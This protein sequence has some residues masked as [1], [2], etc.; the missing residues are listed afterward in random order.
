MLYKGKIPNSIVEENL[1]LIKMIFL[2]KRKRK[3]ACVI[4]TDNKRKRENPQ[5]SRW[6]IDF[7]KFHS[8]NSLTFWCPRL[9]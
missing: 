6:V 3:R 9:G 1:E 8:A 4:K 5:T 2:K 7:I